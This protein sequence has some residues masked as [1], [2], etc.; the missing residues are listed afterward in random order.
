MADGYAFWK[1]INIHKVGRGPMLHAFNIMQANV[2][3][4]RAALSGNHISRLCC[5]GASR[6]S[7]EFSDLLCDGNWVA[8]QAEALLGDVEAGRAEPR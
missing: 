7:G 3:F 5:G 4:G 2:D 1:L 6:I 8:G